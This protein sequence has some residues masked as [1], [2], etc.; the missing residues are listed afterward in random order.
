MQ[1]AFA[2]NDLA[3]NY[4]QASHEEPVEGQT[5]T[6]QAAAYQTPRSVEHFFA[7]MEQPLYRYALRYL[8]CEQDALEAVQDALLKWVEKKYARKPVEQWRPIIY[9][10]LQNRLHDIGRHRQ[11]VN[12][13]ISVFNP[14]GCMDEPMDVIETSQASPHEQPEQKEDSQAFISALMQALDDLPVR[15]RQAFQYRIGEGLSTRET[16][17][18]MGCGEGSVMTHLSR[19]NHTLRRVLQQFNDGGL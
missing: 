16:A 7:Q 12:K 10:I 2:N 8:K 13:V 5:P 17:I 4:H 11:V 14:G 15:Q 3:A 19:A 1:P 9:R 6:P 18:A